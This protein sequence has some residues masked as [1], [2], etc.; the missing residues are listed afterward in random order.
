MPSAYTFK[1]S[2]I[3][4]SELYAATQHS[5]ISH[6]LK[7][8]LHYIFCFMYW[9]Q[10][11]ICLLMHPTTSNQYTNKSDPSCP[12]I[13]SSWCSTISHLLLQ[14]NAPFRVARYQRHTHTHTHT[15]TEQG[16]E[17]L[18]VGPA[19]LCI[20][21]QANKTC[22]LPVKVKPAQT[23]QTNLQALNPEPSHEQKWHTS[24]A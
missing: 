17:A 16:R 15:S 10:T 8:I 12:N 2:P 22:M 4:G 20:Q 19:T 13:E 3:Q 18:H 14:L 1:H 7:R 6:T 21:T 24:E 9:E 11:K 23:P 5:R